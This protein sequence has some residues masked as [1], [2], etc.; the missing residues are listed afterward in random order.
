MLTETHIER[1]CS[2]CAIR[3]K[4]TQVVLDGT[5]RPVDIER[6]AYPD[7]WG[8]VSRE[9]DLAF[10]YDLADTLT[11]DPDAFD[12]ID[13]CLRLTWAQPEVSAWLRTWSLIDSGLKL[14][15]DWTHPAY[16]SIAIA[17]KVVR[18]GVSYARTKVR[19]T[20]G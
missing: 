16:E 20:N 13:H 19:S 7:G 1:G 4:G 10:G 15:P 18:D 2:G 17:I 8:S 14:A 9:V 3:Q 11:H 6:P 5:P 12:P